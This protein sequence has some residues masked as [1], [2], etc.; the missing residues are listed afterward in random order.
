MAVSSV[1]SD[2]VVQII[3]ILR[4][5]VLPLPLRLFPSQINLY[6]CYESSG[7]TYLCLLPETAETRNRDDL[8]LHEL[9]KV[10]PHDGNRSRTSVQL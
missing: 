7:R 5:Q 10:G 3:W 2:T 9:C 1:S 4:R 8:W 6:L